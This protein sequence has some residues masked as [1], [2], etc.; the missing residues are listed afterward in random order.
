MSLPPPSAADYERCVAIS[1][2][3]SW[4]LD[5]VML[6]NHNLDFTKRF[7][8]DELAGVERLP[9]HA[10][11][12]LLLNQIHAN[13]YLNLFVFVE[14]FIIHTA[15]QHAQGEQ[16]GSSSA[17]RALLLVAEVV[18]ALGLTERRSADDLAMFGEQLSRRGGFLGTV[19]SALVTHAILRGARRS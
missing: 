2:R 5:D 4:T 3:V 16:F 9:L 11:E 14:E 7:L 10:R 19:G 17:L 15:M 8:P 12:K 6:E 1:E 18:A 13:S